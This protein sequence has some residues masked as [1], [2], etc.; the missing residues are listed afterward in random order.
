M[1][2]RPI[3]IIAA[4]C[5]LPDAPNLAAFFANNEQSHCAIRHASPDFWEACEAYDPTGTKINTT[6]T[7]LGAFIEPVR[8]DPREF[9][10]PPRLIESLDP[11]QALALELARR[12]IT[13]CESVAP[14]PRQDTAVIVASVAGG[15]LT[16]NRV[17]ANLVSRMWA[18][19]L[20]AVEPEL[21]E[22]IAAYEEQYLKLCPHPR[23]DA[24]INGDAALIAGRITN[25]FNL[26]GP[27]YVIDAACASSHA[28]LHSACIGIHQGE[29]KAALVASIGLLYPDFYVINAQV[30]A[31]SADGSYPFDESANG[32]VPGEGGVM[33][34]LMD[35]EEARRAG[36]PIKGV[37]RG[38][39]F[40]CNG[41]RTAPWAPSREAEVAAIRRA[42][43]QVPFS[44][45]DVDYVEAH[46]TSTTLGDRVELDAMCDTYGSVPRSVP[47]PFGSVKS[48]VGHLVESAGLAGIL[49]GLFVFER[50]LLPPT[51]NVTRPI[52]AEND[53]EAV[54]CLQRNLASLKP[55]AN[56]PLRVGVSSFG[57]GGINYHVLLEADVPSQPQPIPALPP[58]EREPIAV[59]AMEM[60]APDAPDLATFWHNLRIGH[61]SIHDLHDYIPML[62]FFLTDPKVKDLATY[63][64]RAAIAARPDFRD[65]RTF[66]ILPKRLETM[67]PE[68]VLLLQATAKVV[69]RLGE[70]FNRIERDRAG[71]IIGQALDSDA[72]TVF[73]TSIRIESWLKGLRQ[74]L[75][76][77]VDDD[78]FATM[79]EAL[80]QA[81]EFTFTVA[82]EDTSVNGG[83]SSLASAIAGGLDFRGKSYVVRT[84]CATGLSV[85]SL[86]IQELRQGT[87]DFVLCG[88]SSVGLNISNQSAMATIHALSPTGVGRPYDDNGDGFIMGSGAG[89]VALKRLSDAERDGDE[90]IV[91]LRESC[92]SSDGKGRSMLAPSTAGRELALRRV[93]ERSGVEPAT[94]QYLEGHGA[95]MP[96]GDSSEITAAVSVMKSTQPLYIGSVKSNIGHLKAVAG[97]AAFIKTALCLQHKELAPS[98]NLRTSSAYLHNELRPVSVVT[99]AIP[100][101][102]NGDA[103]RRAAVNA[104]GLGGSNYHTLV[105]EY[106]PR[107]ASS[108]AP[109][110]QQSAEPQ[111]ESRKMALWSAPTLEALRDQLQAFVQIGT[112]P[113]G[114]NHAD[115]YRVAIIYADDQ[116]TIVAQRVQMLLKRL[117]NPQQSTAEL[118]PLGIFYRAPE[119]RPRGQVCFLYSGQGSQYGGMIRDVSAYIPEAHSLVQQSAS[120]LQKELPEFYEKFW[121]ADTQTSEEWLAETTHCQVAMLTVSYILS[122]WLKRLNL[123]SD[124]YLGHSFGELSALTAAQS[125]TFADGLRAAYWRGALVNR[126]THHHTQAMAVLFAGFADIQPLLTPWMEEV[127]VAN[128]NSHRQVVLSGTAAGIDAVLQAAAERQITGKRLKI[129]RAFHSPLIANAVEPFYQYLETVAMR[130]PVP[131]VYQTKRAAPYMHDVS[132]DDIRRSLADQYTTCV[133]FVSMVTDAYER[134]ARIFIEVGPKRALVELAKDVLNA[135]DAVFIPLIHPK[136]GE[137]QSLMRAWAQFWAY[138]L[139]DVPPSDQVLT[140]TSVPS[141]AAPSVAAPSVTAPSV[142]VQAVATP[143]APALRTPERTTMPLNHPMLALTPEVQLAPSY[144]PVTQ[145][146]GKHILVLS[147][148]LG[149]AAEVVARLEQAGATVETLIIRETLTPLAANHFGTYINVDELPAYMAAR[150]TPDWVF[151]LPG[152]HLTLK[153]AQAL[154]TSDALYINGIL[155]AFHRVFA[156]LSRQWSKQN[157]G[158][159]AMITQM[160]GRCGTTLSQRIDPVEGALYGL[161]RALKMEI[162]SMR[163]CIL[164]VA[165]FTTV[166]QAATTLINTAASTSDYREIGLFGQEVV[167]TVLCPAYAM[168]EQIPG[169]QNR[170][171]LT[172]ESVV[173]VTGGARGVTAKVVEAMAQEV[174]CRYILIGTTEIID[175]RAA[176]GVA[177]R[178]YL[179][180]ISR[181]ELNDH[182]MRQFQALRESNPTLTPVRFEQH[183]QKIEKSLEVMRTVARLKDLGAKVEY[184]CLDI[185]NPHETRVFHQRLAA[186]GYNVEAII[187]GAAIEQSKLIADKRLAIWD[188]TVA[189]KIN[190]LYN[191]LPFC[192]PNLK[193]VLLFGSLAGAFGG[194]GQTDYSAGCAFLSQMAYRL[195][196]EFPS[197]RVRS[198][199]WPAWNDVGLATRETTRN[200]FLAK[201]LRYMSSEEG[202]RWAMAAMRSPYLMPELVLLYNEAPLDLTLTRQRL[203][204]SPMRNLHNLRFVHACYP[205][206]EKGWNIRWT[207]DPRHHSYLL[208][209]R[210]AN[211]VRLPAVYMLEQIIEAVAAACPEHH[212][213]QVDSFEIQMSLVVAEDRCRQIYVEVE[214]TATPLRYRAA[215]YAYPLLPDQVQVPRRLAIAEAEV[216][217]AEKPHSAAQLSVDTSAVIPTDKDELYQRFARYGLQYGPHFQGVGTF[218]RVPGFTYAAALHGSATLSSAEGEDSFY[219]ITLLDLALQSLSYLIDEQ[220]GGLPVRISQVAVYTQPGIAAQQGYAFGA[221]S[222]NNASSFDLTITDIHGR[223]LMQIRGLQL[224]SLASMR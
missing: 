82:S 115:P 208:D 162:P 21:A 9:R 103:P 70:R 182:K 5:I 58:C 171:P 63:M 137:A 91:V 221:K 197:A 198:I 94:V 113:S 194:Y 78:K 139:T 2:F 212:V 207:F 161:V 191:L 154:A 32:F 169:A 25:Y 20:Q 69:Q 202:V 84:A 224:A 3:A 57:Y 86:A 166:A 138:G 96:S 92:G 195:A 4:E 147:D 220:S 93:Y 95:G 97:I 204:S 16:R 190:G 102:A 177:S 223:V 15:M 132:A 178:D 41:R 22:A 134:G 19:R 185:T 156:Y 11:S 105:E 62:D 39:G 89:V 40:S 43:E 90:I 163:A 216:T 213:V 133:N 109:P 173:L 28:V 186:E 114:R 79:R 203:V 33:V 72:E 47:L 111:R 118:E 125:M 155:A 143:A 104:F 80:F 61:A 38:I 60:V 146:Q 10:L 124:I 77:Y 123:S 170:L 107:S 88:A 50:H 52:T 112:A 148:G 144:A 129:S 206:G 201:D 167:Q 165:P 36:Y 158:G 106:I 140:S 153:Q 29:F 217:V 150:P 222:A 142:P 175:V 67:S 51:V 116:P 64:D 108:S 65:F 46:G 7:D 159:L 30:R 71:C 210:V 136:G 122:T 179:M 66:R 187:H 98:C 56:R 219:N 164:D 174:R 120:V 12:V 74:A 8:L 183:W 196:A 152:Y 31:L 99:T 145:W 128:Y 214:P 188:Q 27:H 200:Y 209:H 6:Y 81:P 135:P 126:M 14:L 215:I 55:P 42:F 49:R 199:A 193:L 110:Q 73:C 18:Q 117:N 53:G 189:I 151:A 101:P 141:V 85:L 211:N 172:E 23:E 83:G 181:E 37:I 34:V 44:P 149:L 45:G 119:Q 24:I 87:L 75:P 54:L 180:N 26:Q 127:F 35:L 218:Y 68:L 48:M 130:P 100:W 160:D 184:V 205:S 17:N 13:S 76:A 192:G 168:P 121:L 157:T 1:K 131:M 59:V 176:L